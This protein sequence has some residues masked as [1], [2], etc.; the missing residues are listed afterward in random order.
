M[1]LD[2]RDLNTLAEVSITDSPCE[3]SISQLGQRFT[4]ACFLR[5]LNRVTADTWSIHHEEEAAVALKGIIFI[6][7]FM[8]ICQLV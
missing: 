7:N 5:S 6:K 1:A 4:D 3:I 8:K 2:K